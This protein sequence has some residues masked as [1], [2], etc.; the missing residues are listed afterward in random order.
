MSKKRMPSYKKAIIVVVV[1]IAFNIFVMPVISSIVSTD[2]TVGYTKADDSTA[3][4]MAASYIASIPK[5][6]P[7]LSITSVGD[8]S[9]YYKTDDNGDINSLIITGTCECSYPGGESLSSE[10]RS[11][12]LSLDSSYNISEFYIDGVD[13]SSLKTSGLSMSEVL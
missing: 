8:S 10:K 7:E 3:G 2:N 4:I 6:Y 5:I 1:A 13:I 11:Y 9:V 12:K